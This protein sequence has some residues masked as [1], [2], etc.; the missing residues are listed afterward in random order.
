MKTVMDKSESIVNLKFN[1]NNKFTLLYFNQTINLKLCI[2]L[3]DFK[4]KTHSI[5]NISGCAKR[6]KLR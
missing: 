3:P 6:M 4:I 5:E 1:L 2:L